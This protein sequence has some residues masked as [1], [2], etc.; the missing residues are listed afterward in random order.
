LNTIRTSHGLVDNNVYDMHLFYCERHSTDANI[1]ITTNIISMPPK[2]LGFALNGDTIK[3]GEDKRIT[4]TVTADT[5]ALKT[6]PGVPGEFTW[7]VR[8]SLGANTTAG[9]NPTLTV[10]S[11]TSNAINKSNEVNINAQKAYTWVV[12][13]GCYK[14]QNAGEKCRDTL[15]WVGPGDPDRVWIEG[16]QDSIPNSASLRSPQHLA[17]IRIGQ[18]TFVENFYG[19]VRDKFGNWV[20]R[21]GTGTGAVWQGRDMEWTASVLTVATGQV[22]EGNANF[23]NGTANNVP[24][25][26]RGQ[27]RANRVGKGT[28]K[29]IAVYKGIPGFPNLKPDT[30]EIVVDDVIYNNIRVVVKQGA[31]YVPVPTNTSKEGV[32]EMTVGSDTTLYVELFDPLADN[33]TGQWVQMPATWVN[34]GT[35]VPGAVPPSSAANSWTVKPTAPTTAQGGGT[36]TASSNGLT[37]TV[38]ITAVNRDPAITRIFSGRGTPDFTATIKSYLLP[39]GLPSTAQAYVVPEEFVTLTA[40]ATLPLVSKLFTETTPSAASYLDISTQG[41]ANRW[42][43]SFAPGSPEND[44]IAGTGKALK[45]TSGDSVAFRSTVA[46]QQYRLRVVYTETGKT[47]VQQDIIIFD[48][49]RHP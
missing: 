36:I 42:V 4:A 23:I 45:G 29:L 22:A 3:A 46:H 44:S 13:R 9:A 49:S 38:R 14:E 17:Q 19:I 43:W 35:S 2:D 21:A 11:A 33:G 28:S 16:S 25:S 6:Y 27:G 20:S 18:E 34:V 30:A 15:M 24:K 7:T 31:I 5:G 8:D 41:I 1:R 10:K 37:A 12:L 48:G 40:G 32:I 26:T 47:P 39:G